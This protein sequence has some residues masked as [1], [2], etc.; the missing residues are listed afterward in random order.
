[1]CIRDSIWTDYLRKTYPSAFV[2]DAPMV[3]TPGQ[4]AE[5][6]VPQRLQKALHKVASLSWLVTYGCYV[7]LKDGW[8]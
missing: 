4:H 3:Q 6:N 8:D 5:M 1:M 2:A 7:V